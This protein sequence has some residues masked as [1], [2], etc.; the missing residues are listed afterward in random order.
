MKR[1]L[2][3]LLMG[4][5]GNLPMTAQEIVEQDSYGLEQYIE[6]CSDLPIVRKINGGTIFKIT[7]E[8][9][10]T[11][12]MK[13][14]FEYACKIWEESLPNCLPIN[15]IAK[16]ENIRGNNS[17]LSKVG[18]TTYYDQKFENEHYA[19]PSTRV[20]GTVMR[21]YTCGT[22]YQFT[23]CIDDTTFFERP[24]IIVTYNKNKI[25]DFS[26]SL[27]S[28]PTDKFDF[29][30]IVLRDI[31]KGLGFS[32][33]LTANVIAQKMNY[34]SKKNTPFDDIVMGGIGQEPTLAYKKATSG[35][36]KINIKGLG[37]CWLYAPQKWQSGVSLNTFLPDSTK[38]ITELLTYDFGRGTVIRNIQDNKYPKIFEQTFFW[39]DKSLTTGF[40]DI[41]TPGTGSTQNKIPFKEATDITINITSDNSLKSTDIIVNQNDV[42]PLSSDNV[43]VE[44]S[45]YCTPYRFRLGRD[46]GEAGWKIAILK[47]DGK[48]DVVYENSNYYA[49]TIKLDVKDFKF[50]ES[51]NNYART[52]DGYLRC[53]IVKSIETFDY[54]Y[55]RPKYPT[56]VLYY[57]LDYLPQQIEM[58]YEG[59][60]DNENVKTYANEYTDDI[61]IGIK[62][63][64]GT[65]RILVEQ[66]EEGNDL[67]M[68]FEVDDFKKGYFIATVDKELYNTFR[69]I[70]INKN[71]ST[72]SETIEIPPTDPSY[73]ESNVVI[74]KNE[75]KIKNP[76]QQMMPCELY[77]V[78][79]NS[80]RCIKKET[81]IDGKID[82]SK[83]TRG[84]YIFV[85]LDCRHNK[86]QAISF[87][88]K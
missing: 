27:Y 22:I 6:K 52:C 40:N 44:I 78:S 12:E 31:A 32:T 20:K 47:K 28:T 41:R 3:I 58:Q 51:V 86:R 33:N 46:T 64:E 77:S 67:P 56:T 66:L 82:I 14:A 18:V 80:I 17:P 25:N 55:K 60:I 68:T 73:E 38:K 57:V 79:V 1:L 88:K 34:T 7:Y 37:E 8:G 50:H 42:T 48:W 87:I 2:I 21:E 49:S 11:N 62:N 71:G 85:I 76:K 81:P 69:V 54:L 23:N 10:W 65:E 4:V 36:V 9:N 30:T 5:I 29:V 70:A 84:K 59:K 15:I 75:I 19:I 53:R 13:G 72:T 83:L 16:I 61:K 45:Q 63:L 74:H 24:D 43:A 26:F 39:D 35:S